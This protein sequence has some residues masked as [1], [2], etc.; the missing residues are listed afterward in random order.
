MSIRQIN[1][2]HLGFSSLAYVI[3][4]LWIPG[5]DE[6]AADQAAAGSADEAVS[7]DLQFCMLICLRKADCPVSTLMDA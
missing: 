1:H 3:G 6:S 4:V 2:P 7:Q 5:P